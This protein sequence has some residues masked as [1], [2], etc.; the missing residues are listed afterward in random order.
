MSNF[1][2]KR[3]YSLIIKKEDPTTL[4]YIKFTGVLEPKTKSKLLTSKPVTSKPMPTIVDL[5]HK[6]N[7]PRIYDQGSLGSCTANA[8]CGLIGYQDIN[9]R[10]GSRLFLYYNERMIEN[11]ILQDSGASLSDGILSLQKHGIC[12]ETRWPYIISKFAIKPPDICYTRALLHKAK[13][14]KNIY[15]TLPEMKAALNAGYPFVVGILIYESFETEN[16]SNT[17]IVP[18][19]N[20]ETEQ[21]LGGHAIVCVGYNNNKKVWIMRNSWG[22]SW[23]DKGYFYLPYNYLLN[24]DLTSDLWCIQKIN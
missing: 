6:K 4:K 19:P 13:K 14:V 8:L 18:M 24:S 23:G 9:M 15:N 10:E 5:R 3:K 22:T 21:L 7:M 2:E 16:V 20:I 1:T 17:G 11:S 12:S